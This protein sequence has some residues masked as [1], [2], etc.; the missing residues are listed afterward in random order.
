MY[1]SISARTSAIE[2]P[3]SEALLVPPGIAGIPIK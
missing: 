1:R 2:L 3:V